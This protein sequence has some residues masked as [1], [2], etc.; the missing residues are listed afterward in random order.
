MAHLAN[1]SGNTL[2]QFAVM[3]LV[4]GLLL[5]VATSGTARA[6]ISDFL[7]GMRENP[8]GRFFYGDPEKEDPE[9]D[10]PS[11]EHDEQPEAPPV[12]DDDFDYSIFVQKSRAS[13]TE[14]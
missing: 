14:N 11:P 9:G 6:A 2:T 1:A 10:V 5:M 8:V 4:G 13:D 7:S 3:A 12:V